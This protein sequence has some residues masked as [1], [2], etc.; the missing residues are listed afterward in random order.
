MKKTLS[1][2]LTIIMAFSLCFG[3]ISCDKAN[4]SWMKDISGYIADISDAN[5]LGISSNENIENASVV[6]NGNGLLSIMPLAKKKHNDKNYIVKTTEYTANDPIV[7]S[8][9]LKKVSFTK[10]ES[11]N[12][13]IL[14]QDEIGGEI[15]KLYVMGNHTFISFVPEGTSQRPANSS[16]TFDTDGIAFYDKCDYFSNSKRQ[17]FIMDN[18]T[19]YVYK[20]KDFNI[21]KI[22]GGCLLSA[23]D[24]FI[25]DFKINENDEIEIF[26][27]FTNDTVEWYSCFKDK[28]GNKFIQNNRLNTYDATT[29]T[30]FYVFIPFGHVNAQFYQPI[31]YELTSNGECIQIIYSGCDWGDA[32]NNEI[33]IEDAYIIQENGN[34]R[35]LDTNDSFKIYYDPL[36]YNVKNIYDEDDYWGDEKSVANRAMYKVEN[37][38]LYG[39]SH[40]ENYTCGLSLLQYDCINKQY[41]IYTVDGYSEEG[42]VYFNTSFLEKYG[43]IIEYYNYTIYYYS[44]VWETFN[45][46]KNEQGYIVDKNAPREIGFFYRNESMTKDSNFTPIKVLENCNISDDHTSFLT[47]GIHGNTYYDIVAE[48]V[49]G[50]IVINQY[51]KGTYEKPQVKIILQPLNN[52]S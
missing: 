35:I 38:I 2:F 10:T 5:A 12:N 36:K 16:L 24:N 19:G 8:E 6:S 48:E 9:G 14:S 40:Y 15:D 17:S 20:L 4:T 26:S 46:F 33:S 47:Y 27:L 23:D 31:D 28:Y 34:K 30:Y 7:S 49:D 1:L 51:V 39:Y 45:T 42:G 18:T 3:L 52:N 43:I 44:N 22:Q 11:E 37:G 25:Y 32:L 50:E 13:E 29:N 21:K 41:S